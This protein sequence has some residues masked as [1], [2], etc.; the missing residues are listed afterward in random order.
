MCIGVGHD[1]EIYGRLI[2]M[3]EGVDRKRARG[4]VVSIP[5][6]EYMSW[7]HIALVSNTGTLQ[8]VVD[9]ELAGTES[10]E[11]PVL[12]QYDPSSSDFPQNIKIRLG[13]EVDGSGNAFGLWN[14]YIG[15]VEFWNRALN[16]PEIQTLVERG[17]H[18]RD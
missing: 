14:G 3:L 16:L 8:L 17:P 2:P 13:H 11:R 12:Y 9:G 10:V 6:V 4:V 7:T 5:H 15:R 18:S 1:G